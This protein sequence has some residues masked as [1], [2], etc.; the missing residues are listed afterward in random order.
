M[1]GFNNSQ[2]T[3]NMSGSLWASSANNTQPTFDKRAEFRSNH[4][5]ARREALVRRR[6]ALG[7]VDLARFPLTGAFGFPFRMNHHPL[8][9][10]E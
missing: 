4:D 2:M 10:A 9:C 8:I 6:P 3:T 5:G 7:R 1:E